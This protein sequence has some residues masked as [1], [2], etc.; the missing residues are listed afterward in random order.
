MDLKVPV[1]KS[2]ENDLLLNWQLQHFSNL[3][4][5]QGENIAKFVSH[6]QATGENI[7]VHVTYCFIKCGNHFLISKIQIVSKS[8]YT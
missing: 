4:I 2:L 6:L 7:N 8:L 3:D 5:I 1:R